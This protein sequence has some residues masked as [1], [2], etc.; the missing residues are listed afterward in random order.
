MECMNDPVIATRADHRDVA[1]VLATA[2]AE[3]AP[4]VALIPDPGSRPARI[5]RFFELEA[6]PWALDLGASWI[7]REGSDVLGAAV[8]LPSARRHNPAEKH[9]T[10]IL[11]YL[12]IFGRSMM[13]ARGFIE[14]IE[15]A[16]PTEDHLYLPFIGAA[17]PGRGIG[18]SLLSAITQAA[19]ESRS[20]LYLEASS[21]ASAR[22]YRR[23]GFVDTGVIE[24]PDMPP[25]Y[26]MWRVPS[27][28]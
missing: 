12:R 22:L 24:A 9:P 26:P 16:H 11:R 2:F 8:V 28:S 5:R 21:T 10:T 4:F 18:G 7:L 3:D 19:D 25:L 14:V 13:K 27:T 17:H 6:G 15:R 23:H 20:P 1:E